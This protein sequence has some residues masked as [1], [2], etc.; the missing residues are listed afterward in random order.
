MLVAVQIMVQMQS[1]DIERQGEREVLQ[2]PVLY[3]SYYFKKHRSE[4]YRLLQAVRDEGDW[5]TWIGF[6][7]QG[8]IEVSDQATETARRTRPRA[9]K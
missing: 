3:L 8:V 2:K 4:Y 7:L 9:S 5:E 6:F 1:W